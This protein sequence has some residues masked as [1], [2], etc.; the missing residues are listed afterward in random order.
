L[1]TRRRSRGWSPIEHE[2][3]DQEQDVTLAADRW[4]TSLEP[5]ATVE[6]EGS[7]R[8]LAVVWRLELTKLAG[9][10]R[11]Q[12]VASLCLVVP[13]LVVAAF[14]VQSAVPQDTLFGQW[15]HTSGFAV[16]LV[17]L[18]FSGQWAMPMLTALVSGD[19]F[20]SEDHFGTW[21]TVLTRS[22]SRG[23][24]FA[25]KLSA[26]VTYSLVML[27]LLTASS[28]AAGRVMGAQ[29]LVGL[30]G[31]L[32]RG[33]HAE[34]LVLASW[35][36]QLAPLLG[37]CALAVLLSVISRNSVVGIG[38]PVLIGLV[39]QLATLVSLP[40]SLRAALLAT[41]FVSWHGIWVQPAY[42]GPLVQGL[43]VSAVWFAVCAGLAWTVF[44]YRS[45]AAS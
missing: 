24:I 44:R 30:S 1:S 10:I 11:V 12:A 27:V 5:T 4:P 36:T 20:S 43:L 29:P 19:I 14:K 26:A 22:R 35:A 37:F 3:A 6:R 33:G 40:S 23:Q 15:V 7:I 17:I 25:G 13:F 42:Y 31:Q 38:G 45:I 8:G 39:M 32:V 34:S 9:Q 18:G 16:P 28:I 41:P 21:K 2:H